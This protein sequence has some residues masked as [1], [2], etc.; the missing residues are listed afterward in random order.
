MRDGVDI[1][2]DAH[3]AW[4]F[5]SRLYQD[6]DFTFATLEAWLRDNTRS[7]R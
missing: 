2:A 7:R 5:V 6:A 4:A 3:Q 1:P